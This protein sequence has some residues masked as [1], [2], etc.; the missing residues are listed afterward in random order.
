MAVS[1]TSRA[2]MF[3]AN[4]VLV[5]CLLSIDL[6]PFIPE[7]ANVFTGPADIALTLMPSLPKLFAKNFAKRLRFKKIRKLKRR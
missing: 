4:G 5:P 2:V 6:K 3:L 7:A 1:P